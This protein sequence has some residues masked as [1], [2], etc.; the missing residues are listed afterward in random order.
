MTSWIATKQPASPALPL[1]PP[2]PP[3][4]TS[5]P[6]EE[7]ATRGRGINRIITRLKEVFRRT[8]GGQADGVRRTR[9]HNRKVDI[10]GPTPKRL[11]H[12]RKPLLP[13]KGPT[14]LLA[15]IKMR[16][17]RGLGSD[18][19]VQKDFAAAS[20]QLYSA[21]ISLAESGLAQAR[22]DSDGALNIGVR[23]LIKKYQGLLKR[24]PRPVNGEMVA[25][26]NKL[27]E[28]LIR[29]LSLWGLDKEL[30]TEEFGRYLKDSAETAG[31]L[32]NL[33][34]SGSDL[35]PS[36]THDH[37]ELLVVGQTC[38]LDSLQV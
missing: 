10:S 19:K 20:A 14:A 23:Q 25:H 7:S 22:A 16:V 12:A 13:P 38:D 35:V 15:S 26:L 11:T 32:D 21:A 29:E 36:G 27:P 5:L 17:E 18:E 31:L 28:V 4:E 24:S 3:E 34:L 6:A 1:C 9:L 37:K 30:V 8:P 33:Q 2:V